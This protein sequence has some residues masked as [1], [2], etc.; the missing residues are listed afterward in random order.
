M[1]IKIKVL[2]TIPFQSLD[3][4]VDLI[5]LS[6]IEIWH[7]MYVISSSRFCEKSSFHFLRT[8][9]N[10]DWWSTTTNK[11]REMKSKNNNFNTFGVHF[12]KEGNL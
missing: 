4:I 11:K 6:T 10:S 9:K 7:D 5:Y 2:L 1:Q 12:D 8:I 3:R